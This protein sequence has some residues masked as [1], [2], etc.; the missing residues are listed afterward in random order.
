MFTFQME[1]WIV[2]VVHP[3]YTKLAQLLVDFG[4]CTTL[5][6][7]DDWLSTELNSD[8][9]YAALEPDYPRKERMVFILD[10]L[11]HMGLDCYPEY[12]QTS[13]RE[14]AELIRN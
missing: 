3:H 10:M 11:Y 14:F 1:D 8:A 5:D 4:Y 12:A 13:V 6:S 7:A 2:D 9:F